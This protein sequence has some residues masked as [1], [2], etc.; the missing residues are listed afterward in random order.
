LTTARDVPI[1]P[2]PPCQKAHRCPRDFRGQRDTRPCVCWLM[3]DLG[4][5]H[6]GEASG[7]TRAHGQT[8]R[9]RRSRRR[10]TP[11]A[12]S[13]SSEHVQLHC[14]HSPQ[15]RAVQTTGAQEVGQRRDESSEDESR[16][17]SR[18]CQCDLCVMACGLLCATCALPSW[19]RSLQRRRV[20]SLCCNWACSGGISER[21]CDECGRDFGAR[22]R[23]RSAHR[24]GE[25]E[26]LIGARRSH[27]WHEDGEIRQ[28]N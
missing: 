17:P 21:V 25:M 10:D 7:R 26:K 18:R 24:M 3:E 13:C 1:N 5:A 9:A 4:Q 14:T 27:A 2:I 6:A 15:R 16:R 23:R 8:L 28:I 22:K 12:D 19:P 11:C 20:A